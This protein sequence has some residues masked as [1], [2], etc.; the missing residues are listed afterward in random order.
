[1]GWFVELPIKFRI[2]YISR[3]GH[4]YN[5][6]LCCLVELITKVALEL[7]AT[8]EFSN[9]EQSCIKDVCLCFCLSVC[10]SV[11]LCLPACC[12][13]RFPFLHPAV[14]T[15]PSC[16]P[17]TSLCVAMPA[18]SQR[19]H[20]CSSCS[21]AHSS[22]TEEE[23]GSNPKPLEWRPAVETPACLLPAI[24]RSPLGRLWS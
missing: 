20:T 1:M 2:F 16:S 8:A 24:S 10:P 12:H 21:T 14:I 7:K 6:T 22:T 19:R 15:P 9:V 4:P 11:R 3:V 5:H 23:Q 13:S 17:S 18:M